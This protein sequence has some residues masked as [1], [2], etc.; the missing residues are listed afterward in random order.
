MIFAF[1]G[2]ASAVKA[3]LQSK[4]ASLTLGCVGSMHGKGDVQRIRIGLT[5]LAV[6]F[7]LVLFGAAVSKLS[8]DGQ[9]VPNAASSAQN[10][11]PSDPLSELGVAP[12]APAEAGNGSAATNK[13]R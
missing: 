11:Q 8:R 6:V 13:T 9:V 1:A 7:L 12:G 10:S 5:G 4:L 3:R 2:R